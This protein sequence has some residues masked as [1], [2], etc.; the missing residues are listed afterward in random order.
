MKPFVVALA[1]AVA[2]LALPGVGS[3]QRLPAGSPCTFNR[4][5]LSGKCRGG[6]QQEVPGS[7]AAARRLAMH[8]ERGVLVRQMPGRIEQEVPGRLSTL[9]S[10]RDRPPSQLASRLMPPAGI[11]PATPC[12]GEV[13]PGQQPAALS[14]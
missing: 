13:R 10:L 12:L 6:S 9:Q 3:A 4:D 2:C 11:E 8:Q 14:S 5:C 1:I 7:A